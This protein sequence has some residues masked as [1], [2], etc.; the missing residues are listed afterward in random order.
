MINAYSYRA[1]LIAAAISVAHTLVSYIVGIDL[2][3]NLW[4]PSVIA[5]GIIVYLI[6]SLKKVRTILGG[7][8]SFTEGL[9]NF[10]IM[11]LVYVVI[12]QLFYFL[13]VNVIDPEFGI[14]V[15]DV[16]IEK[17]IGMMENFGAP[18]SEIEKALVD[19]E[20]EFESKSTFIGVITSMGKILAFFLVV[21]AIVS[22]VLK[23]KNEGNIETID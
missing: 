18:E 3:T 11:S 4:I 23:R 10:F 19:M 20:A 16:I 13:I 6:I 17:A 14:A 21:G 1:G 2:F 12:S 15:N 9:A 8:M 22:A 7:Y 5:I